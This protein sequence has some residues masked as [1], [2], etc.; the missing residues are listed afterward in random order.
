MVIVQCSK[1]GIA[2]QTDHGTLDQPRHIRLGMSY[3]TDH[4]TFDQPRHIIL[5][6]S[7][8]TDHG[9]LD[10]PR[11]IRLGMSY[12]TDHDHQ[13]Q[14]KNNFVFKINCTRNVLSVYSI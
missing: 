11:H 14:I 6:M 8:W 10:Q 13:P 2:H 1:P 12:W 4:G 3:W 7:Y 5:G 9:T